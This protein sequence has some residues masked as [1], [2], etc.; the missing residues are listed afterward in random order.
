MTM[1]MMESGMAVFLLWFLPY[2]LVLRYLL[3]RP[4]RVQRFRFPAMTLTFGFYIGYTATLLVRM[5]F[6]SELEIIT[7]AL[8]AGFVPGGL[9]V[10]GF[11]RTY[12][13]EGRRLQDERAA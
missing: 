4:E 6:G 8:I 5:W 12:E 7:A 2:L 9:F 10:Y 3:I 11:A 1:E 13:Q